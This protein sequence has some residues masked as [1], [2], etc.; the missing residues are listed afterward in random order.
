MVAPGRRSLAMAAIAVALV[1]CKGKEFRVIDEDHGAD[2]YGQSDLMRAVSEMAAAPTSPLAY[3][4]MAVRIEEMRYRFNERVTDMAE[5]KLAFLA[6]GPLTAHLVNPPDEQLAALATTVWPTAFRVE[7][8]PQETPRQYLERVCTGPLGGECK[9]VVPEAWSIVMNAMVWRRMKLRAREAYSRCGLCVQDPSYQGALEAYDRWDTESQARAR[10]LGDRAS[11]QFWPRAGQH[12]APWSGAPLLEL[13][14]DTVSLAGEPMT[15]EEWRR[16]L[17]ERRDGRTLLGVHLRP[18]QEVR[19]L[20]SALVDAARG[21]WT[22]VA[23]QVREGTYPWTLREYR[24]STRGKSGGV[25]VRDVDS[26]Q[27]LIQALD[28]AAGRLA[29]AGGAPPV[30][31]L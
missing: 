9:Y 7:P 11:P 19:V 13:G 14:D 16:L 21:G 29:R 2:D 8:E 25:P 12:A 4:A 20:R 1:G 18:R 26:I 10:R 23:L 27:V 28:I 22:E 6:L 17:A 3:R 5:L 30:L 31:S 24:L 15:D